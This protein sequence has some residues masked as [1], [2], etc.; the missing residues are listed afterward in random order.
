MVSLSHVGSVLVFILAA[1]L[2]SYWAYEI[3]LYAITTYGRVIQ[4]VASYLPHLHT[5]GR[6][7]YMKRKLG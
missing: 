2:A 6:A 7:C 4:C 3:R 5:I 1:A